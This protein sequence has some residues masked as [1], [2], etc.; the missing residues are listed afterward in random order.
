MP[1]SQGKVTRR[2][3]LRWSAA[4]GAVGLGTAILPASPRFA[5]GAAKP[6]KIGTEQPMTGVAALGGKTSLVGIQM[7][8]DRINQ[9]GG[10]LGRPVELILADDESKPD[11]GRRGVEK[12]VSEDKIDAHVGGAD[13][14]A[15]G[16]DDLAA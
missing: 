7:A 3:V 4:G 13:G 11:V 14:N 16:A 2:R 8:V 9:S 12:L 6:F 10:I 15:G 1:H 5:F